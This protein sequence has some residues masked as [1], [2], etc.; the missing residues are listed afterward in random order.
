V[1]LVP[2]VVNIREGVR[3]RRREHA[4]G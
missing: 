4:A 2:V 3:A 1:G